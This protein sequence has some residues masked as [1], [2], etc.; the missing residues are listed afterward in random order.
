V[1]VFTDVELRYLTGGRQLGRLAT[2][3]ADGTPHVV[4]VGWIYN[5]ARD[6]I[7]IGGIELERSKKFRD[8]ARTSRA[9]IVID[10]L[11]S[12][13]PWRPRGIEV[14]GRAEAIPLPTP[15]IR[16][17]PERIVSW[18]LGAHGVDLEAA[19]SLSECSIALTSSTSR[20][21]TSPPTWSTSPLG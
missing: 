10:D 16:I 18:G 14:R 15:L 7:E 19:R 8:I 6:A 3:G 2:V 20:A 12:T 17:H 9:A 4:P 21:G 5:A 11:E 13:D 1:S